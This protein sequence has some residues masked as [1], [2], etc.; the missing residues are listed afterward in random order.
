MSKSNWSRPVH[1]TRGRE[2]DNVGGSD[3]PVEF[4]TG[5]R[6]ASKGKSEIRAETDRLVAEFLERKAAS[7]PGAPDARR[8][9][10]KDQPNRKGTLWR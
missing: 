10:A 9:K 1:L 8:R 5:P 2:T 3:V 6:P 7:K 4:R